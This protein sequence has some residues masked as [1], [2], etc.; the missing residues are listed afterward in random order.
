MKNSKPVLV[1]IIL[2]FSMLTLLV[3]IDVIVGTPLMTVLQRSFFSFFRY[4]DRVE[5]FL[6]IA[7]LIYPIIIFIWQV[8][9]KKN[10]QNA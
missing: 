1:Y 10:R 2:L 8:W 6:V 3:T 4:V 7:L 9:V 5:Y